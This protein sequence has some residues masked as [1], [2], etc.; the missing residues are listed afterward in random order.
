MRLCCDNV[1][2]SRGVLTLLRASLNCTEEVESAWRQG[3]GKTT[4]PS[5][6]TESLR[7]AARK[8]K[9][10]CLALLGDMVV[11][12][13]QVYLLSLFCGDINELTGVDSI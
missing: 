9:P 2:K 11:T 3:T 10:R 6:V 8:K 1:G 4:E 13:Q 5:L 12:Q 7:R